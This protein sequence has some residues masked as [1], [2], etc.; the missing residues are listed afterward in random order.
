MRAYFTASLLVGALALA[1]VGCG[2]S[3]SNGSKTSG[4]FIA[5]LCA[6]F[7]D[8]C[9]AAGRPS[10]G[11][12]CRAFYGAFAP[13]SGYDATA[14]DACLAEVRATGDKK[15]D[16]ASM[17]TPSCNKVFSGSSG[18][19]KPGEACQGSGECAPND[20]GRVDCVSSFVNNA[21]VQE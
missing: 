18:T 8:C 5:Q 2:E 17:D 7:S 19:K 13:A 14:A 20:A 12:Q 3:D 4:G 15:C 21:S 11:A 1:A 16:A 10:D 9:K 6:E